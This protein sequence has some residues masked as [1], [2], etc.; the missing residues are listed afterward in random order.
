M[1]LPGFKWTIAANPSIAT[2]SPSDGIEQGVRH[3]PSWT[4]IVLPRG[5]DPIAPDVSRETLKEGLLSRH[6]D[7]AWIFLRG[8]GHLRQHLE[9]C[10]VSDASLVPQTK[11]RESIVVPAVGD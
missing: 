1:L 10:A 4:P 2:T 7:G 5:S 11:T 3:F 6:T 8:F 9:R